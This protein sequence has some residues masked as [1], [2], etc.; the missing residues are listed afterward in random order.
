MTRLGHFLELQP[1]I[2]KLITYYSFGVNPSDTLRERHLL[3]AGEPVHRNGSLIT[4]YLRV[5]LYD[6]SQRS[7]LW[8]EIFAWCG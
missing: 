7:N 6:L 4:Y 3:Y 1:L 5:A 2:R 8:L